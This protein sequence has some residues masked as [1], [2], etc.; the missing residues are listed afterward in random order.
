[1]EVLL[2]INGSH[3]RVNQR[4]SQI[5]HHGAGVGVLQLEYVFNNLWQHKKMTE[6]RERTYRKVIVTDVQV[7]APEVR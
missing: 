1:M 2:T 6:S 3:Q 7:D 4:S 5:C